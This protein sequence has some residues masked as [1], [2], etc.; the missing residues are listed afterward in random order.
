MIEIYFL[1]RII[2]HQANFLGGG[3]HE[4]GDAMCSL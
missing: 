4:H 1:A 3:P 2:C